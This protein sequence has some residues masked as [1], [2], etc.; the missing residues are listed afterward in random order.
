M[1][2]IFKFIAFSFSNHPFFIIYP[3]PLY[4]LLA[5]F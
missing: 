3:I 4:I 1:F 2:D 5:F